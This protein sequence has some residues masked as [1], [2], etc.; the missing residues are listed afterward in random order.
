MHGE[1]S[2]LCRLSH[3][4]KLIILEF[5]PIIAKSLLEDNLLQISAQN[6]LFG[7]LNSTKTLQI[8]KSDIKSGPIFGH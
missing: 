6:S 7:V 5:L 4:T 1:S 8:G 2:S 3:H